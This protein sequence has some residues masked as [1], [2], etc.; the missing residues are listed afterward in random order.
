[1]T[2]VTESAAVSIQGMRLSFKLGCTEEER[3]YPQVVSI[4]LVIELS[5]AD[6]VESDA[7][8]DTV[9]YMAVHAAVQELSQS[10]EWRLIERLAGDICDAVFALEPQTVSSVTAHVTKTV[11]PNADGVSAQVTKRAAESLH[12]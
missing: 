9:D 7:L 10:G 2:A 1:M 5:A 6:S 12:L 11:L 8:E 4:D 3:A